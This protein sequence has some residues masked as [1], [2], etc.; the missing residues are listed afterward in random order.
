MTN[1]YDIKV[2]NGK[3]N[4]IMTED[5]QVK[6]LRHGEE[7]MDI[8]KGS[9]FFIALMHKFEA[10]EEALKECDEQNGLLEFLDKNEWAI[11]EDYISKVARK[12]LEQ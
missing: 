4:M 3:Y 5:F 11:T 10:M 12:A 7:W 8:D 6:V 9:K 1:L 2:E